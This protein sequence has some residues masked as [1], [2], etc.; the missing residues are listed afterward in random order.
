MVERTCALPECT[1]PHRARGLCS[2]HYNLQH[3][4]PEQRHRKQTVPC[5]WCGT[6]CV[7]DAGRQRRYQLFCSLA[8]RDAKRAREAVDRK[9]PVGPIPGSYCRVPERHPARRAV[10]TPRVWVAGQCYECGSPFVAEV[11]NTRF[12]SRQCSKRHHRRKRKEQRG[13]IIGASVRA[14]VYT[15]DRWTCWLCQR[16]IPR[17]LR[18]PHP[19]SPTVD[20]VLPQSRGGGHEVWNLRAAHFLCNSL[21]GN[22]SPAI[23]P[24]SPGYRP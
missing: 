1:K 13:H 7:K 3:S 21:R 15:R 14:Y 6:D 5:T 22:R 18:A 2:T 19:M 4:T 10:V 20:H 23:M 17:D 16:S 24:T 8:C 12:C 9:L 11:I